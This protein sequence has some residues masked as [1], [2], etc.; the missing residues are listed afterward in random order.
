M[1]EIQEYFVN[2]LLLDDRVE[3]GFAEGQPIERDGPA[4]SD[5]F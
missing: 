3:W 4:F 5:G 1:E 2:S